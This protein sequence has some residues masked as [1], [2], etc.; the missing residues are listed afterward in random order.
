VGDRVGVWQ[1]RRVRRR[2]WLTVCYVMLVGLSLAYV[3]PFAW[4][5]ASSLKGLDD[6][7]GSPL[8]LPARPQ[9]GNYTQV[10]RVV[11]FGRYL[12]NT[13]LVTAAAVTGQVV[14]GALVAYAF[15]RLR[16]RGREVCFVLLLS[17]LMLPRH[18]TIVPQYVIFKW[19]GWVDGYKP[20]VVP[21]YLGGSAFYI[22]LLRQYLLTIPR[23]L[24]EAARIDG[25]G[26]WRI[27]WSII[28]PNAKPALLTVAVLS[29]IARW[30]DLLAPVVYLNRFEK[31]TVSLGLTAFRSA[32]TGYVNTLLAAATI[33]LV[34][35]VVLF[36]AAQRVFLRGLDLSRSSSAT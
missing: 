27:F 12:L 29:F 6:V 14:S 36:F 3:G 4:Q 5:I 33:A 24:E 21:F 18:V 2:V 23:E 11:P 13:V 32:Q 19:L 20:L 10:F 15:A 30:N 16:W 22:F 1:R 7:Y 26:H 35:V 25:A 31:Y 34:P 8:R 9:W 28:A 17:T